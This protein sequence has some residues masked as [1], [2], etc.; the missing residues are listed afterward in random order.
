MSGFIKTKYK[1]YVP[2][3]HFLLTFLFER[4]NIIFN[5][6]RDI[7]ATVA[8]Q[9]IISDS[10]ERFEGYV[11]AKLFALVFIVFIWRIIFWTCE[12]IKETYVKVFLAVALVGSV[13][14][15][16]MWP[17]PFAASED[18]YITYAYAIRLWPEYWHS[19]Y[20]SFIFTACMMVVPFPFFIGVFQWIFFTFVVGYVY[21]R[22]KECA[23]LPA[24]GKYFVLL[25]LLL[26]GIFTLVSNAYRTEIY[27]LL[28][29]YFVSRI[30]F[31]MLDEKKASAFELF[32]FM[33][34]CGLISVWRS[35]GIILGLLGF[36][37]YLIFVQKY[38]FVKVVLLSALMVVVFVATLL[39]QKLGD[40]K[41]Y[42]K[43]YSF[44]NSFVNLQNILNT[45]WANLTYDGVEKDMAAFD[46][47]T[48]IPLLKKYG[49][50]GYRRYN[51][52]NGRG[53]INQSLASD[54]TAAAYMDAYYSLILHNPGIY[55]R[56]QLTML[57][58]ILMIKPAYYIAGCDEEIPNDLPAWTLEIVKI[59]IEDINNTSGATG[60]VGIALY[61]GCVSFFAG[62]EKALKAIYFYVA[63][64]LFISLTE[65]FILI[66]EIVRWIKKKEN[67]LGFAGVSFVLMLQAF[68]IVLV[69]PYA[70]LVYLHAYYYSSFIVVLL[71]I[72]NI[73]GSKKATESK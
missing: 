29:I 21:K 44:I 52:A 43:D 20:T 42:G 58:N 4:A 47:V 68:A 66:R 26:P 72:L 53:D 60:S 22:I 39:P 48:P 67:L 71:Y 2:V 49:M 24:K 7:I 56:T 16:L 36:G 23:K 19:A 64:L 50:E 31:D 5:L 12:N 30:L 63:V 1:L 45:P 34:L 70:S 54:E 17:M 57:A 25:I 6:D 46:A 73:F 28:C 14:F 3:F 51:Y 65:V 15:A 61:H 9:D 33:L 13:A 69:L 38:K 40:I 59:G 18:N 62:M 8:K 55:A 10:F 35:E 41:Y 27:T 11:F 37:I 32:K